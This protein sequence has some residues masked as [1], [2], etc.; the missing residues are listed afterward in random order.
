MHEEE[1]KL[2]QNKNGQQHH[3]YTIQSKFT[4]STLTHK[5]DLRVKVLV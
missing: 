2:L 4:S 3:V 1:E 5:D